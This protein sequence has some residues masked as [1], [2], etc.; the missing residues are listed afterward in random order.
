MKCNTLEK[1]GESKPTT[2]H[3]HVVIKCN[4][5]EKGGESKLITVIRLN[6]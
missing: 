5:L 2:S 6:R 1:G 4:T 3:L